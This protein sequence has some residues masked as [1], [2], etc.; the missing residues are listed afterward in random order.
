MLLESAGVGL[1]DP[2]L[3]QSLRRKT[4]DLI[5]KLHS[6]GVQV[7]IDLPQI[8][9]IG[10]QSAGKSSLIEA[11]SGITLPR[12]AGTCTRCPTECRLS[13]SQNSWK[14]IVSL[15]FITD[16]KGQ[17]LGQARNE[18]FGSIITDKVEVEDRIR[19]AQRAILNP[20][21]PWQTFLQGEDDG[22]EPELSF[23]MN[24]VSLQISGPNI[25]DLSFCDLPGLIANVRGGGNAS[26]IQLVESLVA[27]YIKKPSCIILLTVACETDFENQGA[28]RL[29]MEHDPQGKRT[30]GVLTKPDRIP[31][32]EE[33]S[34]I[35]FIMNEREPLVNNWYCVKQPS[36]NEIQKGITY[37]EAR[38]RENQ[39]FSMTAPW[40]ELEG[41]YQKF[42]RTPNLVER[43]STVL[44][45]L[46][47]RR[48]PEIQDELVNAIEKTEEQLQELPVEPSDEPLGEIMTLIHKF[49]IDISRHS[50]GIPTRDGLLQTIRPAQYLFRSTIR[51]TALKFVPFNKDSNKAF[52]PPKFLA[53]EDGG[54]DSDH[55][56]GRGGKYY[57]DEV[58]ATAR[59]AQTRELPGD[60]PFVVK[61]EYIKKST[62]YWEEP[63]MVLCKSVYE[64]MLEHVRALV[65]NHF[66]SYGQGLLEKRVRILV[67]DH[68]KKCWERTQ[69]RIK[70][71]LDLEQR[72]STLNTHYLADY[73]A[74]YFTYF[75]AARGKDRAP[76]LHDTVLLYQASP[77]SRSVATPTGIARVM[78]G[79]AEMNITNVRPSDL[80]KLLPMDTMEPVI[81]IM[82]DVQAYFKV[83]HER[84][85]DNVPNVI[86][87][88]L[89][90]GIE[91][92]LLRVLY[93]GLGIQK[94]DGRHVCEELAREHPSVTHKRQELKKR[95]ERLETASREL[96]SMGQ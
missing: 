50:E 77:S 89:V 95:L 71:L 34:W 63:A 14:C 18:K 3:D 53:Q 13:H 6:T 74:K 31:H 10:N 26:D 73:K 56:E 46:I 61:A 44:S 41:T 25:A 49:M 70:W 72:P 33:E 55:P 58:M 51:R 12:A 87:T 91:K 67:Q 7:D 16:E 2:E 83:S 80:Q 27:S 35:S 36:S 45:D 29:A 64:T 38:K 4:L 54:E 8:A 60:Y 76:D 32:G 28:H 22:V 43:L 9:V 5:N 19:R 21:R 59:E 68:L 1:S 93:G 52:T 17:P 11:I 40:S 47:S 66:S 39:F 23:S 24:C 82:A 92:D 90:R 62:K 48:L 86:D 84:F 81:N 94:K 57:L 30:I 65:G 96:L 20:S 79:L 78:Q 15:R 75:M 85:I 88:E 42:L 37:E 69:E